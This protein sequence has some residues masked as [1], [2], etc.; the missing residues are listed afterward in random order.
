VQSY[1]SEDGQQRRRASR[2]TKGGL[3]LRVLREVPTMDGKKRIKG[4]TELK[5]EQKFLR[6]IM[7]TI[8]DSMVVLDKD[9]RIKSANRS[10]YQ[11]FQT[12]PEKTIGRKLA[13]ILGDE[14]NK[15]GA[16]L[17]RLFGTEDT[18][19]NFEWHYQSEKLGERILNITARGIIVA[20]EEEEEEEEQQL[21]VLQDITERKRTEDLEKEKV[22]LETEIAERKQAEEEQARLRQRLEALWGIARMVDADY[23]TL[24]DHILVQIATL[25][26]SRY[27]F[28]GFLNDDES[29]MT[30]YSW[31]KDVLADCQIQDRPVEFPIASVGLWGDAV[32]QRGTL[33]INDYQAD[34]PG[35][36]GL[37]EGHVPITRILAVPIF[38]H[39]HIAALAV[40]GNKATEYTEEDAEQINAFVTNAQVI[41]ERRQVEEQLQQNSDTQATLN[42]LLHISLLDI[43]LEEQLQ[44]VL[45]HILSIPWLAFESRGSIF[46]VE[47]E[48]DVLVMKVQ[49][50]LAEAIQKAC[51]RLPFGKCLC[52]RA[53]LTQEIQFADRLD[54]RH[55]ITYDGMDSHGHYC[56]PIVSL[57]KVLGV[58][59]IYLKEGHHR[60][61]RA[62]EFLN[63]VANTLAGIIERKQAVEELRQSRQN[64]EAL[65]NSVEG[66]VWEAD[67]RTFQFS[68]VSQ[69]AER[70]LGYP[71]ERWLTEPTFWKDHIHPDD[72]EWAVDYC[73][74]ATK[75]KRAHEFEYRMIAA[76]GRIVWLRDIVIVTVENDKPVK[77]RGI[78][79]D[80]TER[81]RAEAERGELERKAHVAG[82]LAIVGEMA[83]GIAHEINN[84]LT[85]VIGFTELLM[86]KKLSEDVAMQY[87]KVINENAQ[88]ASEVVKRLL[89]FARQ[90]HPKRSSVNINELLENTL[91]LRAYELQTGNIKVV[92]QL[93]PTLR[94]TVA[95]PGQL[96]Q[97]FLNIILNA[98]QAMREAHGKGNLLVKTEILD[99]TIRISFKDD[100][101]GIPR[102]NLERIFDPFFTTNKAGEGT[103]L[104]L[105]I[106]Y[107]IISEH[108]G[109]IYA[110]SE[111]G[112]GATF[113]V[114]L[115]VLTKEE[116]AEPAVVEKAEARGIAGARILVVD[117][118]PSVSQL[119]KEVLTDEGYE[120]ETVDNGEAALQLIERE[121]YDLILLDIKLPG[122]SGFD[123]YHQLERVN[124]SLRQRIA[125]ITGDVMR[126]DTRDFLSATKAPYFTKPFDFG[127]VK[128]EIRRLLTEK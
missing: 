109:K 46:L 4:E 106:C 36:K 11:L 119:L 12:E 96:Q 50:G 66:I 93:D 74:K 86:T 18:L 1:E 113:V 105:S 68:F 99:N 108:Q 111:L 78:M 48:P 57:G 95:D 116:K 59:N 117:D 42:A 115:P 7:A 102:E 92:T 25:T 90:Y 21:V 103:G 118:E 88:R 91:T 43:S 47:D 58:I 52:G 3:L 14:D 127:H 85:P 39:G 49:T 76:D 61:K 24:C 5:R 81:K 72:Q 54:E 122:M 35:K 77:L 45:E 128:A 101:P 80:M 114:E 37:P 89:T 87:L 79:V 123:L 2:Q 32:R 17:I 30:L 55:E 69:Q 16:Q 8:P 84:P 56:V 64:Y 60:D 51:A 31:S 41:V 44:L 126:T 20:E 28:F 65:V 9:L 94:P 40:V 121:R 83:A 70:L 13:N 110:E 124:N 27:G 29:V 82:R 23:Q 107:G 67:A 10:F 38:S 26:Q 19:E 6:N 100:G 98:E 112:K 104:G 15:L 75:E 22:R 71:V 33:I 63:A 62:E 73:A 53:A 97:V 120:V 34:H 125:F